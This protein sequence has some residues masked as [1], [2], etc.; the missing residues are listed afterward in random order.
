M[1]RTRS[2]RRAFLW[3]FF[4]GHG[5]SLLLLNL[6]AAGGP[7]LPLTILYAPVAIPMEL[8]QLPRGLGLFAAGPVVLGLYANLAVG[9]RQRWLACAGIVLF[10][11]ACFATVCFLRDVLWRPW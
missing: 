5:A 9:A 4:L 6:L 2:G 10:H 1:R 3:G 7:I 11:L 8:G